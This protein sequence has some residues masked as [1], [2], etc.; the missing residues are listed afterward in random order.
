VSHI[1]TVSGG[2]LGYFCPDITLRKRGLYGFQAK[3]AS[4]MGKTAINQMRSL[5][6]DSAYAASQLFLIDYQICCK[7]VTAACFL[8]QSMLNMIDRLIRAVL[9]NGRS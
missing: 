2:V 1:I 8:Q 3:T 4:Q 9:H 5:G 7:K 6:K